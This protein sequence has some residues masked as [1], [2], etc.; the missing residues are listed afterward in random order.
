VTEKPRAAAS[1]AMARPVYPAPNTSRV[2]TLGLRKLLA[3]DALL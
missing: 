1:A 2:A 3:R